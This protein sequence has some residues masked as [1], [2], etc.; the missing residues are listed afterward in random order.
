[1]S[2]VTQV[3]KDSRLTS[4]SLQAQVVK[5]RIPQG[6]GHG[7][8]VILS[9]VGLNAI[10]SMKAT[11]CEGGPLAYGEADSSHFGLTVKGIPENSDETQDSIKKGVRPEPCGIRS[12]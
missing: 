4:C 12:F 7:N 8:L 5:E 2:K 6:S 1:M 11:R 3:P 10:E 9:G